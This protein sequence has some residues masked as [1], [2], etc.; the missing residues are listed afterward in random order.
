M[1]LLSD[2]Y[3]REAADSSVGI[4]LSARAAFERR[5]A[6]RWFLGGEFIYQKSDGYTPVLA[7][8]W[9]RY[10]LNDWAGDLPLP[11]VA[12]EPYSEWQ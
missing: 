2:L 9:L 3:A 6:D 11:P 12:P 1:P 4:G 8:L 5:L 10:T 7:T